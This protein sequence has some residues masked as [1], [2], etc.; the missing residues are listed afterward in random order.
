MAV[1]VCVADVVSVLE[2][3]YP[4]ALAESWDTGIG[5]T[6]GSPA[7]PVSAV[8]LAVDMDA[9]VVAQAEAL[10]AQLIVTH[11]PMLFRPLQSVAA[12]QPKGALIFRL[13]RSGIAH[14]SAHTNADKAVDGVNDAL[15]SALDLLDVRPLVADP[16]DLLPAGHPQ[17]GRTG[18]GRVGRVSMP[19]L[20]A[21][22]VDLVAA[23]LPATAGGVRAAGDPA[24][25]V[26]GVALCGGAGE[27]E[28]AAA[29]RAGA[30]VYVT[31]DL[32]HH[33]VAEYMAGAAAPAVVDVPHWAGEWPWLHHAARVITGAVTRG[34]LTGTVTVTVSAL[35]T[36][37]W[38]IHRGSSTASPVTVT[39]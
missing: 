36:D 26:R 6:C 17:A 5:L 4:S 10:G 20:L 16:A 11:H 33:V 8:L 31:S 21:E 22:F 18:A 2:G 29:T 39:G 9:T 19:L 34:L 30:D 13:I 37:P 25:L 1:A 23:A 15:A 28:L 7:A 14:Y 35:R 3:A 38:T 32:R 27:S 12:D 24:R